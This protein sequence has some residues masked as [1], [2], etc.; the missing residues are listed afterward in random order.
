MRIREGRRYFND[1]RSLQRDA[2]AYT[3]LAE[4]FEQSRVT[5]DL[6]YLGIG[7]LLF[8]STIA[9][10]WGIERIGEDA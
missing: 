1:F 3:A 9:L 7:V 8:L 10:I 6:I 2:G 4:S 5:V